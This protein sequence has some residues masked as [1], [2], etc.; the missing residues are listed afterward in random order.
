MVDVNSIMHI[1]P[2]GSEGTKRAVLIGINYTGQQ[3]E[4]RGCHNDVRN[5]KEYLI[6]VQGFKESDMLILMDDGKH[7]PPTKKN[8]EQAFVRITQYSQAGDC[9]FVHYSGHGG[10]VR[11]YSGKAFYW[12]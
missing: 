3:G 11:D 8:I 2:P 6:R 12:K 10:R 5:I 7:H 4:L 1:V 9:V